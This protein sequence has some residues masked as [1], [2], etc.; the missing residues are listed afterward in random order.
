MKIFPRL[1]PLVF[2]LLLLF[3]TSVAAAQ[4]EHKRTVK[5]DI[6]SSKAVIE[7]KRE[8][9]DS[10][11][12]LKIEFDN[13]SHNFN[14]EYETEDTSNASASKIKAEL[15]DLIEWRD[16][17]GNGKFDPDSSAELIQKI[18][19]G[20]LH[21][22]S[23]KSEP[24][25][26]KDV[27]GTKI[28][29]ASSERSKYPNLELTLTV[30]MFGEFLQHE[31]VSLEPTSMKFDIS[32]KGFPFMRN[33]TTLALFS[34]VTMKADEKLET[35][36]STITGSNEKYSSFFSWGG[37][38]TVDGAEKTPEVLS[39]KEK[40][41]GKTGTAEYESEFYLLYPR[42]SDIVHDPVIGIRLPTQSA[43]GCN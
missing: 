21:S 18:G 26:V 38:L 10:K 28:T 4:E 32:I 12:K 6:S 39:M 22:T 27:S 42:G 40:V 30:H 41:E 17:N 24:I 11:D 14:L 35:S 1:V 3:S 43:G 7:S 29:G 15:F 13:G 9:Q 37:N 19:L 2:P 33:D 23:L 5:V 25:Q 34:K 36:G 16:A 31:G 8:G 20:D